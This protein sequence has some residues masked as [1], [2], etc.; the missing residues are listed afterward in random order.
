M[1]YYLF[2]AFAWTALGAIF[3]YGAYTGTR[4]VSMLTLNHS[5]RVSVSKG[6]R[7]AK[8]VIGICYL[9]LG[10]AYMFLAYVRLPH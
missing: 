7:W 2:F 3:L 9:G 6:E 10:I 1:T 8:G 4:T 5:D